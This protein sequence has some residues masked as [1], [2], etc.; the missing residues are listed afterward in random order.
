MRAV[1]NLGWS[2]HRDKK[3]GFAMGI[4]LVG[5]VAAFFFRREP[6]PLD[7]L[8]P[9]E[10]P[11]S[12]DR[13][14][15]AKPVGPYITGLETDAPAGS[16]GEPQ[17]RQWDLPD[18]YADSP[19]DLKSGELPPTPAAPAPIDLADRAAGTKTE[20]KKTKKPRSKPATNAST[21]EPASIHVGTPFGS[22]ESVTPF[23]PTA[24]WVG[25]GG[26]TRQPQPPASLVEPPSS[27]SLAA[28]QP[29]APTTTPGDAPTGVP[30]GAP[31][32]AEDACEFYRVRP[33]DTLS[34]LSLRFLGSSR[35]YMELYQANRD[36]LRSPD[37]L[38]ADM[39]IRIPCPVATPTDATAPASPTA[40]PFGSTP[41]FSGEPSRPAFEADRV[42]VAPTSGSRFTPV[43]HAPL[44]GPRR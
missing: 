42:E 27:P 22:P 43:R 5:I 40:P 19:A 31:A 26:A 17:G 28:V 3:V 44:I 18:I 7:Q 32:F 4:L 39:L 11:Q 9:L 25:V 36:T 24:G 1:V 10:D 23:P 30:T 41:P 13:Q 33:G 12:L 29:T 2:M 34:D 20:P 21:S 15:A 38:R 8:P 16:P 35:R 6:D 37:D 14:I